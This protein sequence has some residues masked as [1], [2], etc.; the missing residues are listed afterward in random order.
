MTNAPTPA[1]STMVWF[2]KDE[3]AALLDFWDVY[4]T[5]FDAISDA[6]SAALADH[7]FFGPMMRS[8]S[9]AATPVARSA[10]PS[11]VVT[12]EG[13]STGVSSS[14]SRSAAT[15]RQQ[16][17]RF[18]VTLPWFVTSRKV[19]ATETRGQRQCEQHRRQQRLVVQPNSHGCHC[20][21]IGNQRQ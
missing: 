9:P 7:P 5:H 8:A 10:P 16:P 14:A 19:I 15:S 12:T 18:T 3:H 11:R 4:E 13:R 1:P 2:E 20:C 21:G 17:E 6:S